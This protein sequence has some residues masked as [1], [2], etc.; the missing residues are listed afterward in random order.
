[1]QE[2]KWADAGDSEGLWWYR[3]GGS[4]AVVIEGTSKRAQWEAVGERW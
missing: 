4:V 2:D 3:V 1:M